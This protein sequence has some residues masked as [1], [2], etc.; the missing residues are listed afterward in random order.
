M[1]ESHNDK[2]I[3][4]YDEFM[5]DIPGYEG[6]YA[7][8]NLGRVYSYPKICNYL[9]GMSKPKWLKQTIDKGVPTVSLSKD[10]QKTTYNVSTLVMK[11]FVGEA[12][13]KQVTNKDGNKKNCELSNLEY[14]SISE[15]TKRSYK[16]RNIEEHRK[17]I[18]ERHKKKRVLTDSQVELIWRIKDKYPISAIA[19]SFNVDRSTIDRIY[20]G[21]IYKEFYQDNENG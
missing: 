4:T 21:I 12:Q 1:I 20:K 5:V 19:K 9:G 2:P 13:G 15:R 7:V 18:T 10:K 17:Q 8:T 6:L 16:N 3:F 11:T 14:I